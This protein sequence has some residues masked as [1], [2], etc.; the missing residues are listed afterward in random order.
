MDTRLR[1]KTPQDLLAIVPHLLG[2]RP[3]RS[4]VLIA[5]AGPGRLVRFAA[6]WDLAGPDDEISPQSYAEQAVRAVQREDVDEVMAVLY[7]PPDV[8]GVGRPG[9]ALALAV[10]QAL[11]HTGTGLALPLLEILG[12]AHGRWWSYQCIDPDCCPAEGHPVLEAAEAGGPSQ[13]VA[14]AALAGLGVL[15]DRET[16]V[17]SVQPR[18]TQ[19]ERLVMSRAIVA[20]LPEQRN[21]AQ[22]LRLLDKAVKRNQTPRRALTTAQAARLIA[23]LAHIPARDAVI[24]RGG[25]Y[26]DWRPE[27]MA[28]ML[29]LLTELTAVAPPPTG[30]PIAC[31]L[32]LLAYQHGDGALAAIAAERALADQADYSCAQ[33]LEQIVVAQLDPAEVREFCRAS[34]QIMQNPVTPR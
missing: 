7:D 14:A 33:L 23:G 1:L 12:V 28:P 13:V 3:A 31:I 29:S 22:T 27:R 17:R 15:P 6:R 2:F 32:G 18:G 9:A 4:L 20:A 11:E 8:T 10:H 16:L 21:V 24:V 34:E 5:I 25:G 30:A 26:L 19:Q